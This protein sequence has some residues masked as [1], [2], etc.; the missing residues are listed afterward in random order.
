MNKGEDYMK[1]TPQEKAEKAAARA[2]K[3]YADQPWFKGASVKS[4]DGVP[5]VALRVTMTQ[6]IALPTV[7]DGVPVVVNK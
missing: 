5:C 6:Q 4:V 1:E 3:K 2:G 7:F